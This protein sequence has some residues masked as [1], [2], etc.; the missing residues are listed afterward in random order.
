MAA[1]TPE[2][3]REVLSR[4]TTRLG[5]TLNALLQ[6]AESHSH[7]SEATLASLD[8]D[9]FLNMLKSETLLS[10][11][12]RS[13]LRNL[14]KTKQ[15]LARNA[16]TQI[17]I[18]YNRVRQEMEAAASG[19]SAS[20]KRGIL[21]AMLKRYLSPAIA[22]ALILSRAGNAYAVSDA[23]LRA[24]YCLGVYEHMLAHP[25]PVPRYSDGREFIPPGSPSNQELM[26]AIAARRERMWRFV[27]PAMLDKN[28]L[29][30]IATARNEGNQHE[31]AV[32]DCNVVGK[33]RSEALRCLQIAEAGPCNDLSW[34]PY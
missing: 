4:S 14:A 27:V 1:A 25:L 32:R 17:P 11:E 20:G 6:I 22:M 15:V 10:P 2:S 12:K 5:Q 23:Q 30:A 31:A 34:M 3:L 26:A 8:D 9:Q 28:D 18:E 29:V 33:P 24:A 19:L 13:A 16:E 7:K 21:S